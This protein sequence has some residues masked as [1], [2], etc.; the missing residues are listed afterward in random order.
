LEDFDIFGDAAVVAAIAVITAVVVQVIKVLGEWKSA[1]F[2]DD[3]VIVFE[4]VSDVEEDEEELGKD[5]DEANGIWFGL[6]IC[7]FCY[8]N[9]L[10]WHLLQWVRML[11]S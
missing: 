7:S 2:D 11:F 3:D 9:F 8:D 1:D 5:D 4:D 10:W 6:E